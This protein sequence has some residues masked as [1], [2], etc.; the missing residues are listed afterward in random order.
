M[1]SDVMI[2]ADGNAAAAVATIRARAGGRRLVFVSGNFNIVHPG[3]V[4]LLKFAAETGEF[5]V[6]G[7]NPDGNPGVTVPLALRMEGVSSLGVVDHSCELHEP[8]ASFI[9][10][11]QPEV[12]VK[13]REYAQRHNPEQ[14]IVDGYG[15]KLLFGSGE[16][17]FT[18]SELLRREMATMS[19][20]T[21]HKPSDFPDRHGF[22]VSALKDVLPRLAGM[23]VL[24]IGDLI[25][26]TYITCDALGMSQEDPTI[27][28]TPLEQ[29]TFVGGAGIVAAHVRGLGAEARYITVA[30]PDEPASFARTELARYGVE[31][32]LLFD[33]TR[34]TTHK[35][36]YRASGK[37]L[38]RVNQLRQHAIEPA[39]ADRLLR[40][41]DQRLPETD[42]L[43]FS[44]FNYGC[45]PQ[46]VVEAVAE[47]A[48]ARGIIMAADSQASSQFADIARFRNMTLITPT[49]RE[50]R[51][52]LR[53]FESGLAVLSERLR[54]QARAHN[55][56]ITLGADGLMV[57]ASQPG[58]VELVT[59]RLPAF[60]T[61]PKDPAGAGDSLFASAS[62][63]LCAGV[64]IWRAAYLGALAAACQ[65]GRIGNMPVT[66]GDLVA[67][68]DADDI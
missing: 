58:I 10:R 16:V 11:L 35:Q 43:L 21:L 52:A 46:S 47:R 61:A 60:N 53:D 50:A 55:V 32:E 4:R 66:I 24:V 5:L 9:A 38:L 6:V 34:P 45:L 36:R 18:S 64:D 31:A 48:A 12:V 42:L 57:H 17:R 14:A 65:V 44:D 22:T 30:G 29:K 20:S 13:G 26:D 63:A 8:P 62:M 23:R 49:E 2:K 1:A 19:F 39:L 27:V 41:I 28:V 3:H 68:I 56:M 15:G 33:D 51:L 37:T 67:E 59:D 7:V 54:V 40:M 25:V